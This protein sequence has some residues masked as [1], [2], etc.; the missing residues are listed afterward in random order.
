MK[1]EML[2]NLL[3]IGSVVK[4]VNGQMPI[5][6]FGICQTEA[7]SGIE[8]DYSAVVWPAGHLGGSEQYLFNHADIDKI[9]FRGADGPDRDA[10]LNAL[11]E[12]FAVKTEADTT[13]N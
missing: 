8:Y 1:L 10:F 4:L 3:P 9:L 13:K 7:A 6:I 11:K 12:Y 5:M 2:D